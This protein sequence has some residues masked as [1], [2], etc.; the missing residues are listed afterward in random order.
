MFASI[1]EEFESMSCQWLQWK[2]LLIVLMTLASGIS[3][4]ANVSSNNEI[5]SS[6]NKF[7]ESPVIAV[8]LS[9]SLPSTNGSVGGEEQPNETLMC[10]SRFGVTL[11]ETSCLAALGSVPTDNRPFTIGRREDWQTR[12]Q[13]PYRILGGMSLIDI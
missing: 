12:I 6:F 13:A 1:S 2:C 8:L 5:S 9:T 10:S 3:A 4:V 11:D 7:Q